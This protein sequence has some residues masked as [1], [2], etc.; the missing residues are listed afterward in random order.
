MLVIYSTEETNTSLQTFFFAENTAIKFNTKARAL[1]EQ[2]LSEEFTICLGPQTVFQKFVVSQGTIDT[3]MYT[4]EN[5]YI[6]VASPEGKTAIRKA[7]VILKLIVKSGQTD[8]FGKG[9]GNWLGRFQLDS[10][11]RGLLC[12][13]TSVYTVDNT[14]AVLA[15]IVQIDLYTN[16]QGLFGGTFPIS[17]W[18]M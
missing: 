8:V 2:C 9:I 17:V 18:G 11:T 4:S 3:F 15:P 14:L 10:A 6:D 13:Y 5:G 16:L 7:L 1:V 12:A